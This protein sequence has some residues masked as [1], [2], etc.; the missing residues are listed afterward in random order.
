MSN[1]LTQ[2]GKEN[3]NN[4]VFIADGIPKS[5]YNPKDAQLNKQGS[6]A[7]GQPVA[8]TQL[9]SGMPEP[10]MSAGGY[11]ANNG[12]FAMSFQNF[13]QPAAWSTGTNNPQAP[14]PQNFDHSAMQ[15]SAL[16]VPAPN[17]SAADGNHQFVA[18]DHLFN[19]NNSAYQ[20]A[21]S[22]APYMNG[23]WSYFNSPSSFFFPTGNT[24]DLNL[25]WGTAANENPAVAPVAPNNALFHDL[26]KPPPPPIEQEKTK[27]ESV[28]NELSSGFDNNI[29][30]KTVENVEQSF[31]KMAVGNNVCEKDS[32]SV[33]DNLID[34]NNVHNNVS[35][36][37]QAAS[38]Q[39]SKPSP[40][41]SNQ[42]QSNA[43][44]KPVSWA[45][46]ASQP[47]K[48]KVVPPQTKKPIPKQP[49]SVQNG[50]NYSN[51][52]S[53]SSHS[54]TGGSKNKQQP[55]TGAGRY[56]QQ[57]QSAGNSNNSSS[58]VEAK[59]ND[60]HLDINRMKDSSPLLKKLMV[61]YNFN[62]RDFNIDFKNCRFFIIKSYSEDDIFR[63]I[64][65]SSWTST[66]HGNRR[67]NEAFKEQKKTGLKTPMYLL[68][69]VNSS[70]HFCG[71]A[72]MC[73]EVDLNVETGIWV[74]DKWKGRFSVRW[75]YVKDVPNNTLR[76]IRLENNENKP[77]TNSR[78]TQEV[79]PDKGKQ[80]LKIIH[81]YKAQTSIF[82]DFSHYEKRQEEDAKMRSK[83]MPEPDL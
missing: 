78:D 31:S 76:H 3:L 79:H 64:K 55:P 71:V 43:P 83:K 32:T 34:S 77:V 19:Q 53:S 4:A 36:A 49:T 1:Y 41:A 33:V 59:V 42:G 46:V 21:F 24:G 69:S 22:A 27:T 81:N 37:P 18:A 63:S 16:N 26:Y 29:E 70:G 44:A 35:S 8:A 9:T 73:S 30:V 60:S 62:P 74:Q 12:G 40:T 11:Y 57:H 65:Y 54:N 2:T 38:Q 17:Q 25:T 75:I 45:A 61:K 7:T 10:Y 28:V 66:E 15:Y 82:D 72:E 14:P 67:L 23:N 39:P 47:A 6:L 52:N 20:N 50:K 56:K 51:Q 68:Y 5:F 58:D 13:N 80:V 48:N